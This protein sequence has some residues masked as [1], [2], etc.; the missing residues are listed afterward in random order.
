MP[1]SLRKEVIKDTF[2]NSDDF[3]LNYN[4]KLNTDSLISKKM[5]FL[6][7]PEWMANVKRMSE[8]M[9]E[10]F[11]SED[12]KKHHKELADHAKELSKQFN[13]SKFREEMKKK[14]TDLQKEAKKAQLFLSSPEMKKKIDE[15]RA[16]QS[17]EEYK[18]LKKKF[19]AEVEALKK[20]K[21]AEADKGPF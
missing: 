21:I 15:A 1:D 13:S 18:E 6:H 19:D 5:H 20:K 8:A 7:S 16:L 17:S 4:L 14:A 9:G 12:W 2:I 11:K 10:K 3:Y